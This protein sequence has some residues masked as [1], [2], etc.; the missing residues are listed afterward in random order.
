M[1]S[2]P[3]SSP[4]S[5]PSSSVAD[6]TALAQAEASALEEE[7]R[8]WDIQRTLRAL[9]AVADR[10][11]AEL[12][13]TLASPPYPGAGGEA[14]G[15]V[16]PPSSTEVAYR[17]AQLSSTTAHLRAAARTLASET[18]ILSR[19]AD[20]FS[21]PPPPP[22]PGPYAVWRPG[23]ALSRGKWRRRDMT[24]YA[25]RVE[26]DRV[27]YPLLPPPAAA[28]PR[29]GGGGG[30]GPPTVSLADGRLRADVESRPLRLWLL[31]READPRLLDAVLR[32]PLPGA[33]RL[34]DEPLS[35]ATERL[36]LDTV[37]AG[38]VRSLELANASLRPSQAER[39]ADALEASPRPLER[40]GLEQNSL[41]CGRGA[42]AAA[43]LAARSSEASLRGCR[44]GNAGAAAV[45]VAVSAAAAVRS[46][47]LGDNG[48]TSDGAARVASALAEGA[49]PPA[50]DVGQNLVGDRGAEALAALP[51]RRLGARDNCVG[52]RGAAAL[53][54]SDS[55]VELDLGLN[56]VTEDAGARGV[57]RGAVRE[58]SKLERL[59]FV[60]REL[61]KA[62]LAALRLA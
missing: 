19:A 20:R 51:L 2:S 21:A 25:D 49:C 12:S 6:P 50:L 61:G 24:V 13:A 53:A 1:A 29:D 36:L 60:G 52:D 48:L 38:E 62:G 39:L 3:P 28:P 16:P 37:R 59:C 7:E 47:D 45:A 43:R 54:A 27:S 35:R 15:G 34:S 57:V 30:G 40:L 44:L 11:D 32:G 18:E 5:S 9:S 26:V 23:A 10:A 33:V 4:G 56:R 22:P 14:P 8:D 58:E 31:H 46:L 17:L 55:L 41:G 42:R